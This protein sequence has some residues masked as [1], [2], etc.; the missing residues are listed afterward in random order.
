MSP[1]PSHANRI[2]KSVSS[3]TGRPVANGYP[4]YRNVRGRGFVGI[5]FMV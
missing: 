1:K 2:M 4:I 3:M 5:R